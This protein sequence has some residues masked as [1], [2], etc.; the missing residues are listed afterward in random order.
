MIY[1]QLRENEHTSRL[2]VKLSP[3][4]KC[5][6]QEDRKWKIGSREEAFWVDLE[7]ELKRMQRRAPI[8]LSIQASGE[9][10][11]GSFLLERIGV[12]IRDLYTADVSEDF[13]SELGLLNICE[14]LR[15][16]GMLSQRSMASKGDSGR[17]AQ[18]GVV[19]EQY[20]R[21]RKIALELDFAETTEWLV[22]H[23]VGLPDLALFYPE[24]FPASAVVLKPTKKLTKKQEAAAEEARSEANEVDAPSELPQA[25]YYV[26]ELIRLDQATAD[27]LLR[28]V[29]VVKQS[30]NLE[31]ALHACELICSL[32]T[33][34][35][36]AAELESRYESH[37]RTEAQQTRQ[38]QAALARQNLLWEKKPK[39]GLAPRVAGKEI[40]KSAYA[41]PQEK[42]KLS[43]KLRKPKVEEEVIT[44]L[45][46]FASSF[47]EDADSAYERA[48]EHAL[49]RPDGEE[50]VPEEFA[51]KDSNDIPEQTPS[52]NGR[53]I[54]FQAESDSQSEEAPVVGK[55]RHAKRRKNRKLKSDDNP[56]PIKPVLKF[57]DPKPIRV[58]P[59]AARPQ[60]GRQQ[61]ATPK[62]ASGKQQGRP[63]RVPVAKRPL[64]APP[65]GQGRRGLDFD[66]MQPL[67]NGTPGLPDPNDPNRKPSDG[68]RAKPRWRG[69]R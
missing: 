37:K 44:P 54:G 55:S 27:D 39:R 32:A 50:F 1:S 48:M 52:R 41:E 45:D 57:V 63:E 60:N 15:L 10:S 3:G 58:V 33:P 36:D 31:S 22:A 5:I 17:S 61:S 67:S 7:S 2:E 46:E 6:L 29:D 21:T 47:E 25:L 18:A 66:E 53:A 26:A 9:L 24:A 13:L 51:E 23:G 35:L 14:Y 56:M 38:A 11:A 40:S 49:D 69:R 30:N 4:N 64:Q 8:D 62:P 20:F 65:R 16:Y 34:W 12:H 59:Q 68:G 43:V 19:D 28:F 42:G